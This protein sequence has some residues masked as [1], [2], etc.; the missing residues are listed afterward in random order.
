M[1]TSFGL[2][3]ELLRNENLQN[4]RIILSQHTNYLKKMVGPL[5]FW[6]IYCYHVYFFFLVRFLS[7]CKT[8][9]AFYLLWWA[10]PP[11]LASYGSGPAR[12]LSWLGMMNASWPCS[13]QS[14]IFLPMKF[15]NFRS[16][17]T[18]QAVF[19][20]GKLAL[21]NQFFIQPVLLVPECYLA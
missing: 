7:M 1:S 17:P 18:K 3:I 9:T 11:G 20:L 2:I 19:L 21:H 15:I 16:C 12:L 6:H 14:E 13:M 8:R 5:K 4:Y 10:I